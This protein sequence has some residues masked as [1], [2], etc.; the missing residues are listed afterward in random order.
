MIKILPVERVL[1][2][3]ADTLIR[4]DITPLWETDLV[5]KMIGAAPDVG[6]PSGHGGLG[7]P[8]FNAGVLLMD[9]SNI[10][11]GVHNLLD[12]AKV[13]KE[14]KHRDPD[15]LNAHFKGGWARLSMRWNAQGLG[16]YAIAPSADRQALALE[17]LEDATI[18]HFTGPVNP[19]MQNVLNPYVQ[20][21][22]CK[23]WGYLRAPGHP[24]AEEWWQMLEKT[25][26]S[27]EWHK[28][29]E[30]AEWCKTEVEK[31][32]GAAIEEFDEKIQGLRGVL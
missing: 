13:M 2:L 11:G 22:T 8:Y 17:E 32:K 21:C 3:D 5:G 20:P 18:I 16:T 19:P 25:S 30:Y 4:G 15:A 9:L 12:L 14:S 23:P 26:W 27:P 1:Y 6:F 31:V 10:R 29:A 7:G 28:S 24:Y